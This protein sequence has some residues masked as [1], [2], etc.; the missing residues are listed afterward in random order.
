MGDDVEGVEHDLRL[1]EE[2][3][4]L[5]QVLQPLAAAGHEPQAHHVAVAV[6]HQAARIEVPEVEGVTAGGDLVER[7]VLGR[8]TNAVG[9]D[10]PVA[11]M[12]FSLIVAVELARPEREQNGEP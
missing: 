9:L 1:V 5:G 10:V 2:A 7:M 8:V 3:A 6:A 11:R 4:G 12:E